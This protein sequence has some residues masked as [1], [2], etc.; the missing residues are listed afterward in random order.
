MENLIIHKTRERY[1]SHL[2]WELDQNKKEAKTDTYPLRLQWEKVTPERPCH[3]RERPG[4]MGEPQQ[5][6]EKRE[7][8]ERAV[9]PSGEAHLLQDPFCRPLA[10]SQPWQTGGEAGVAGSI[11]NALTTQGLP[12]VIRTPWTP[13]Q[14]CAPGAQV[15]RHLRW[16][17]QIK[18]VDHLS[19]LASPHYRPIQ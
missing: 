5:T 13:K 17:T 15:I 9:Q 14:E 11:I 18:A 7:S 2:L 16:Q 19:H 1:H 10:P 6:Q 4:S 3:R 8:L 12:G